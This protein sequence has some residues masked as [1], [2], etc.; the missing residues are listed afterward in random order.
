MKRDFLQN[1][2]LYPAERHP[3]HSAAS[4]FSSWPHFQAGTVCPGYGWVQPTDPLAGALGILLSST[5]LP[6]STHVLGTLLSWISSLLLNSIE[7]VELQHYF[8]CLFLLIA[9]TA[10]FLPQVPTWQF[11]ISERQKEKLNIP[12]TCT[13]H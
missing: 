6:I 3:S 13:L 2:M 4:L 12:P 9:P 11:Y 5:Q 7:L 10:N 1:S 8:K